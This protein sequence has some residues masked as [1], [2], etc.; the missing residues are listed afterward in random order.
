MTLSASFAAF[1][2]IDWA[3]QEHA[4][5]LQQA[6]GSTL[7]A[8]TLKQ[9]A[10]NLEAWASALRTRFAGRPVAVCL[11]Q[12]RGALAYAL[13]KYEFL[14]LFPLNPKQLARY[15]EALS[16]SGAK[17]DPTDAELLCRFVSQHHQRLRAWR[18]D[19]VTTRGLRLLTE[20]RRQ[21]VDQRTAAGNQLLQR[22]KEVYP[23]ALELLGKSVYAQRFLDLLE[24]F[25]SQQ[26]LH[27]ASPKQLLGVLPKLRRTAEDPPA[28]SADPRIAAIRAARPLVTDEAVLLAGR[29]AVCHLVTELRHFNKTIADY[30]QQIAALVAR[31]PDATLFETLPGAGHALA[32]RLVAAFGTDRERYESADHLAQWS[33]VAPVTERSGKTCIVRKRWCCSKFLRQTFHEFARCSVYASQWAAAY[34]RM[35]RARGKRHHAAIRSLAFK[36]LRVLYR[37]WKDRCAYDEDHHLRQLRQKRS[38]LLTYLQPIQSTSNA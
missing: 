12:S 8:S 14:V 36:W 34:Y 27:R 33:G 3:D 24:R 26:E 4:V 11:E 35:Q 23:L 9:R 21:W 7:E 1:V 2:G 18:P 29:M 30:D 6:D 37:C 20:Q 17:D 31:H 32:P 25:P 13:M 15:R 5:C 10:E 28:A 38:P 16:P 22:L 19:D